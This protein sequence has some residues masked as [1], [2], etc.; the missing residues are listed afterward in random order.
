MLD[1]HA[2]QEQLEALYVADWAQRFER[3]VS[4]LD[5]PLREVAYAIV[6]HTTRGGVARDGQPAENLLGRVVPRF[7]AL[8][9]RKRRRVLE[10]VYLC[11]AP[12]VDRAWQIYR[13]L[14]YQTGAARKA[15]RAPH[16]PAVVQWARFSWL[17]KLASAV[18]GYEQDVVWFAAWAPY[19]PHWDAADAFGVLFA[20]AIEQGDREG[21]AVYEILVASAQGSHEI[22]AMGRHVTRGLL[23]A[24]RSEGW[25]LVERLLLVAQRQE[26]APPGNLG[27]HR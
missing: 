9:D 2:A 11:L 19:L 1:P 7:E 3:R 15:F 16:S 13:R 26:R 24:S 12:Y 5:Q 23:I 17:Q 27:D 20:G 21:Q 25:D 8:S 14:P 10:T 22:G 6:A 4:K 18:A